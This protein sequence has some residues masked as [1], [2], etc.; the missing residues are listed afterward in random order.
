MKIQKVPGNNKKH[1]VF[2]Y[3]LSTCAWCKKTKQF[4]KDKDVEYEYVDVDLLSKEDLEKVKAE[5]TSRG[6]PLQFPLIIID[7]KV[8]ITGFREDQINGALA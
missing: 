8:M 7:D 4:L 5:I 6:V 1:K 3:A 2:V